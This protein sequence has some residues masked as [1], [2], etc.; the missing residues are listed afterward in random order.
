MSPTVRT[1]DQCVTVEKS[2]IVFIDD[3]S[4]IA[5]AQITFHSHALLFRLT[6]PRSTCNSRAIRL[7]AWRTWSTTT[8]STFAVYLKNTWR[9]ACPI[10]RWSVW[11]KCCQVQRPITLL[12]LSSSGSQTG[13]VVTINFQ[14][15][16]RRRRLPFLQRPGTGVFTL[17]NFRISNFN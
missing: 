4:V 7:S 11:T 15:D 9:P 10:T 16:V 14:S 2:D 17:L 12:Y 6:W 1:K 8:N 5:P 13:P 3:Y